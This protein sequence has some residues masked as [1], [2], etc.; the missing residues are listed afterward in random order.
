MPSR[1]DQQ[2]ASMPR[3]GL[4]DVPL[5]AALAG[6]VLGW[7]EPE[8]AREQP[9]ML[10]PRK[11]ADLAQPDRGQRVDPAQAAKPSHLPLPGR[12]GDQLAD[13]CLER[14]ATDLERVDRADILA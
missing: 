12:V 13:R 4:G 11:V 10:E 9:G 6:G 7:H 8:I 2:P 3:A 14:P 1:L 5:P